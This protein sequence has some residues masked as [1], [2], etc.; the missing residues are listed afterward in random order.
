[1][2]ARRSRRSRTNAKSHERR[3]TRPRRNR[4]TSLGS[5]PA[6]G[7][8]S[9]GFV[10]L[11]PCGSDGDG[12]GHRPPACPE[13]RRTSSGDNPWIPACA[14]M[15]AIAL[16]RHSRE[17]PC[18]HSRAGGNPSVFAEPAGRATD[19]SLASVPAVTPAKAGIH[20]CWRS[21]PVGQRTRPWPVSLPSFPRRR[22]SMG[23][24]GARRSGHGHALGQCPCRHSRA[25]GNPSVSRSPPGGPRTRPWPVPVPSFPRRR[26]SMDF[27]THSFRSLVDRTQLQW[28]ESILDAPRRAYTASDPVQRVS[29]RRGSTPGG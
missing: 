3:S 2:A 9:A 14:G 6:R 27:R 24:R 28:P 1:M 18:R 16:V 23:V 20:R 13:V 5:T 29:T 11:R 17:H 7:P 26:E 8:Q 12:R 21:S 15:T 19:T 4:E 25:G 10:D 22:E